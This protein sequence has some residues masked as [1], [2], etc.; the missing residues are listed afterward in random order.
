MGGGF[1]AP[2][3]DASNHGFLRDGDHDCLCI[4]VGFRRYGAEPM[5]EL[6]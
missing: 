4:D 2:G 3:C 1:S 6:S 5:W